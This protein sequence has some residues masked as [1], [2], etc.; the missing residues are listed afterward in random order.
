A[1]EEVVEAGPRARR[2]EER[3]VVVAARVL[4]EPSQRPRAEPLLVEPPREGHPVELAERLAAPVER[5]REGPP[6]RGVALL[7]E[8]AALGPEARELLPVLARRARR[9]E[10]LGP[11]AAVEDPLHGVGADPARVVVGAPLR[12]APADHPDLLQEGGERARL[13]R[14]GAEVVGAPGVRRHVALAPASVPSGPRGELEDEDV[15]LRDTLPAEAPRAREPGDA[16]AYDE[17][18]RADDLVRLLVAV[19]ARAEE[20]AAP[21]VLPDDRALDPAP[22]RGAR[23]HRGLAARGASAQ[24]REPERPGE[25][26]APREV[27]HAADP[28]RASIGSHDAEDAGPRRG[29]GPHARA[30]AP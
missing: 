29:R 24:G 5:D 19:L 23:G 6:P 26:L 25:E 30:P 21:V 27:G 1:R 16:G 9:H 28:T 20:V 10:A 14:G 15:L 18:L 3:S 8:R 2:R 13:G 7:R 22:P 12:V 17:D 11:D 4:E